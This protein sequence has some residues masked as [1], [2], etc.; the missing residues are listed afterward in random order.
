MNESQPVFR[1]MMLPGITLLIFSAFME[2]GTFLGSCQPCT[3]GHDL[4]RCLG[5]RTH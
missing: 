3:T 1:P 2:R 4:P 5:S